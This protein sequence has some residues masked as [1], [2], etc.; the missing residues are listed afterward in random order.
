M[1]KLN[2]IQNKILIPVS[3]LIICISVFSG[4]GSYFQLKNAIISMGIEEARLAAT[5][6]SK[7]IDQEKLQHLKKGDEQ[8]KDYQ[9]ILQLMRNLKEDSGI[10]YLY[11]LTT[12][13]N[14]VYFGV[15][16][17]TTNNQAKIGDRFE[18][19]YQQLKSAF[20]GQTYSSPAI[21]Y[22]GDDRLITVY[23]PVTDIS[24]KV[25]AL[26]GCDY[27][28]QPIIKK[29]RR[30]MIQ[31]ILI[32][33]L[34]LIIALIILQLILRIISK[35]LKTINEK[36]YE[37]V[38]HEGD[39]TQS[40]TIKTGDELEEIA[41]NINH[42]LLYM[43]KIMSNIQSNSHQ[44][45][46]ST[47][48]IGESVDQVNHN[49]EEVS[50]TMEEMS[51][52]MEE[53]SASMA[54]MI[55]TIQNVYQIVEQTNQDAILQQQ[56]A[57]QITQQANEIF[58]QAQFEQ[59]KAQDTAQTVIETVN[60]KISASQAVEQIDTLTKN[61]IDITKQTNLLALNA[62]IEAAR[63]GEAG[64]GFAVVAAEI[65]KLAQHSATTAAD[66]QKVSQTV[67]SAVRDLSQE[68]EKMLTF[69]QEDAMNG[70]QKLMQTSHQYHHDLNEISSVMEGFAHNSQQ[71]HQLMNEIKHAIESIRIAND[72]STQGIVNV[73]QSM[74]ET[75]N[76]MHQIHQEVGANQKVAHQ[77]AN[78]VDKFKLS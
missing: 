4:I 36:I 69:I 45:T 66:I 78:E 14:Q 53:T 1:L 7:V 29:L 40:L 54:E 65:G 59:T 61:I 21:D 74:M 9:E 76:N 8:S 71:L 17:D 19:N 60:E 10:K 16:T 67:L 22:E 57:E 32:T 55:Q 64:K 75:T 70:Y 28:A 34:F 18:D 48:Q 37:L 50:S 68:A 47:D 30:L 25:I 77:L 33:L 23:K 39:L 26:I 12:D 2:S 42:L 35:N 38:H 15:D 24:G 72:E 20:Q 44:L 46:K 52:A 11:T 43:H 73:T 27:D 41:D 51:A 13:G 62:S 3:I 58:N 56:T 63:S 6:V 31:T 5:N 49:V